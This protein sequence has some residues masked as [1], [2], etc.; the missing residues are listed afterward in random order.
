MYVEGG[1][2]IHAQRWKQ[3]DNDD[4]DGSYLVAEIGC[5]REQAGFRE[6]NHNQTGPSQIHTVKCL[7]RVILLT[8]MA[9]DPPVS[10]LPQEGLNLGQILPK[11][12]LFAP[13]NTDFVAGRHLS[14]PALTERESSI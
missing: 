14:T 4:R 12:Q 9:H 11:P 13:E 6:M 1:T 8:F 5:D 2:Q 3:S 10:S 7:I